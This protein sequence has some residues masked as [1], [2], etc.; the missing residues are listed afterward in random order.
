[1]ELHR[2]RNRKVSLGTSQWRSRTKVTGKLCQ[3]LV[4]V[5]LQSRLLSLRFVTSCT[6]SKKRS[7][8]PTHHPGLCRP[9]WIVP[10]TRPRRR[11][12]RAQELG[13]TFAPP[14][15]SE[16]RSHHP[17][18]PSAACFRH[19]NHGTHRAALASHQGVIPRQNPGSDETPD[20]E[21]YRTE[22][23]LLLPY[24]GAAANFPPGNP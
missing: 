8:A 4:A 23:A 24:L 3:W 7:S 19:R 12:R 15:R 5:M 9:S 21:S 11:Q 20:L 13:R 6:A 2:S 22:G 17:S 18:T 10:K 16:G 1:M 14:P